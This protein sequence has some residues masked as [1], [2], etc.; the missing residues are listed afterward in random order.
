MAAFHPIPA[1]VFMYEYA[2]PQPPHPTR[3]AQAP[4][5]IRHLQ[6][7]QVFPLYKQVFSLVL[8]KKSGKVEKIRY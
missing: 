6:N 8:R 4:I 1:N 3:R 7:I 2:C 5:P